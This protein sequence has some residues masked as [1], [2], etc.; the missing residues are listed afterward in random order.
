MKKLFLM[1]VIAIATVTNAWGQNF[2][3]GFL[4]SETYPSYDFIFA[5]PIA[6]Q[7]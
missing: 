6:D 2:P 4:T 1:A 7:R 3:D 5:P